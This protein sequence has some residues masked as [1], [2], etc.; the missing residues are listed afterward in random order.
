MMKKKI[1]TNRRFMQVRRTFLV[2]VFVSLCLVLAGCG[3][4]EGQDGA[5]DQAGNATTEKK[6]ESKQNSTQE[7]NVA[8]RDNST[9]AQTTKTAYLQNVSIGDNNVAAVVV[10]EQDGTIIS[11]K[12]ILG[13]VEVSGNTTIKRHY[14]TATAILEKPDAQSFKATYGKESETIEGSITDGVLDAV[15]VVN[16]LGEFPLSAQE[17][18]TK[19]CTSCMGRGTSSSYSSGIGTGTGTGTGTGY[20]S[21]VCNSCNGAGLLIAYGGTYI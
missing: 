15:L 19:S 13:Y 9:Q 5:K 17:V 8:Q 20:S 4:G 10:T 3:Q 16:G 7:E 1:K 6:E 11:M 14:S 2:L 12:V 21:S 18:D